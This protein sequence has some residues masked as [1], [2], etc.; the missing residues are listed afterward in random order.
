MVP[1][2]V[3]ATI[4]KFAQLP[5]NGAIATLF[6]QVE[7]RCERHGYRNA[8]LDR[9]HRSHWEE[10]DSHQPLEGLP[11]ARTVPALRLRPPDLILQDEMHS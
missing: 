4:D 2:F 3:I 8:D 10:R 1:S 7:G 6:G 5:W 11:A 9:S